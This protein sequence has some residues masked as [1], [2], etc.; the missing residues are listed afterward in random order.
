MAGG[1]TRIMTGRPDLPEPWRDQFKSFRC[2][3][4]EGWVDLCFWYEGIE[5]DLRRPQEFFSNDRVISWFKKD[6]NRLA[7]IAWPAGLLGDASTIVLKSYEAGS[8]FNRL[9]LMLGEPRALRHWNASWLLQQSKINT[10]RPVLVALNDNSR[11]HQGLLAVETFSN[12]RTIRDILRSTTPG[13][14]LIEAGKSSMS[15][16]AFATCCGHYAREIHDSNIVHRD[17]R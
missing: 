15:L 6:R 13:Q 3:G 2:D 8:A 9:R 5:E 17:L 12:C 16:E 11:F 4:W 7:E 10:P 14:G 1:R